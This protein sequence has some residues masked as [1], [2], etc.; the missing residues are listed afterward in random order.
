MPRESQT[1]QELVRALDLADR[2][3]LEAVLHSD[4]SLT[5]DSG[6]A[7]DGSAGPLQ[8]R[9]AV[10]GVVL[11][12]L[13]GGGGGGGGAAGA[14]RFSVHPVNGGPGILVHREGRVMAVL[15]AEVRRNA[16]RALWLVTD[17]EKLGR[18]PVRP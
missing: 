2:S 1:I 8:G 5:V 9:L 12:L 4:V 6:N 18:W 14:A 17:P 13:C 7:A 11:E 10:A 3:V 16:V 15:L